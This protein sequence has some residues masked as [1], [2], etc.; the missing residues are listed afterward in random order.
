MSTK[1]GRDIRGHNLEHLND[2]MALATPG[3]NVPIAGAEVIPKD[4]LIKLQASDP[5]LCDIQEKVVSETEAS[6][7]QVS[8]FK[9]SGVLMRRWRPLDASADEEWRVVH[10]VVVCQNNT[11]VEFYTLLM[12]APW[13]GI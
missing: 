6:Q 11:E 10:Q 9:R 4:L 2:S 12:K 8:Y 3:S 13:L 1:L 5:D 7:N